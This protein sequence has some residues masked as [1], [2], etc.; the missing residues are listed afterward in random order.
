MIKQGKETYRQGNRI[1]FTPAR[2]FK[3]YSLLQPAGASFGFDPYFG[4]LLVSKQ[5][6]SQVTEYRQI[7]IGMTCANA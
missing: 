5:I 7:V 3:R 4:A 1:S 2:T 6:E